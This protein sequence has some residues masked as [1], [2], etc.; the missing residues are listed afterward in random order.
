[1]ESGDS[2]LM[3]ISKILSL[4]KNCRYAIHDLSRLRANRPK[5]PFRMNM[6]FEFGLDMGCRIFGGTQQKKKKCLVFEKGRYSLK[7]A[8]SDISN[9]DVYAHKDNPEKAVRHIRTWFVLEA[10]ISAPSGTAI[11]YAYNDFI[12]DIDKQLRNKK[13][14]NIDFLTLPLPELLTYMSMWIKQK[15]QTYH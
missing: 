14:R 4:I 1:M 9:S 6:P 5:E 7:A 12:A 13:F 3:R 10:H 15:G 11:W 8:L 2:G